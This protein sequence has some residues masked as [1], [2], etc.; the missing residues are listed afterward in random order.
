MYY[1]FPTFSPKKPQGLPW[2][3]GDSTLS[4]ASSFACPVTSAAEVFPVTP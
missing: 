4:A 3:T 2:R 1:S